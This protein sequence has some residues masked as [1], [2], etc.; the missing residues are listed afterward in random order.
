MSKISVTHYLNTTLKPFPRHK[1]GVEAYPVYFRIN[2]NRKNHIAQSREFED[3]Q[4]TV[5]EFAAFEQTQEAQTR[6]KTETNAVIRLVAAQLYLI[7]KPF[8]TKL[9]TAVY[10][11]SHKT[12]ML[13]QDNSPRIIDIMDIGKNYDVIKKQYLETPKPYYEKALKVRNIVGMYDDTAQSGIKE[14][15]CSLYQILTDEHQTRIKTALEHENIS[16]RIERLNPY[17]FSTFIWFICELWNVSNRNKYIYDNYK[18]YIKDF[19]YLEYDT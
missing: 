15:L 6:F 7:Q 11:I 4:F 5:D 13:Y 8:D 16:I 12:A 9:F 1:D 17:L 2:L 19:S 10:Q 18:D 3:N 14:R